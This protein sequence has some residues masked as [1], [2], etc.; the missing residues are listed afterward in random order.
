MI[1]VR[2]YLAEQFIRLFEFLRA[3]H[4]AVQAIADRALQ[5]AR[6]EYLAALGAA[7]A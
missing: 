1:T 6:A 4:G 7:H 5:R 3:A 2:R